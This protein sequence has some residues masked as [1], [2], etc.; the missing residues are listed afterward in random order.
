MKY[1]IAILFS[2]S[3]LGCQSVKEKTSA[4]G[5]FFEAVASGDIEKLKKY[6]KNKNDDESWE[7]VE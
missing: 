3:L 7:E 5:E 2:M 1:L 6:K 4:M